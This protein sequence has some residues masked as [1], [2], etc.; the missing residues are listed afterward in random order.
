[1]CT[2]SNEDGTAR[3][4][5]LTLRSLTPAAPPPRFTVASNALPFSSLAVCFCVLA[6][7]GMS[8]QLPLV[9]VLSLGGANATRSAP[10]TPNSRTSV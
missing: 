10:E 7:P 5:G 1:M 9:A 6:L 2:G 8:V 4:T 3:E